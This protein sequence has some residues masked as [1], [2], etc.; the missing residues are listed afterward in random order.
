MRLRPNLLPDPYRDAIVLTQF[1][2]LSQKELADRFGI[3]ASGA[4]S[5]V[6]RGRAVLKALLLE[7]CQFEFD[8]RGSVIDCTPRQKT[9][10][11]ECA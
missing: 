5:R 2:G 6:Q 1:E 4:K 9:K 10:C 7:C 11:A 3:S 8:R